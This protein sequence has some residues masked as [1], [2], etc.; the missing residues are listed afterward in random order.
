VIH[1]DAGYAGFFA[2]YFG[3]RRFPRSHVTDQKYTIWNFFHF[4]RSFGLF[5]QFFIAM[6]IFTDFFH[7]NNI[8]AYPRKIFDA[9]PAKVRVDKSRK[10]PRGKADKE[11]VNPD[12]LV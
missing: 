11:V 8:I 1:V 12:R 5:P 7:N 9:F 6:L 3:N 2:Q 10:R 4:V